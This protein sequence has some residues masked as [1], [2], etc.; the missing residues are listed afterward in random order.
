[1]K[2]TK[3]LLKM[4]QFEFSVM[5]EKNIFAYKLLLSLNISDIN[6]FFYAK[7]AT[8]L[9][10]VTPLVPSNSPL[11]V[12]VLSSQDSPT[13]QKGGEG[14]YYENRKNWYIIVL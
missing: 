13:Q 6:L 7:T 8:P 5:T 2:V 11:N 14:A 4:S 1:M 3:F 9:K 10:K 12:E